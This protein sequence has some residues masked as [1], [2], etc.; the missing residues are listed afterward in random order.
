MKDRACLGLVACGLWL[1]G[2]VK[3]VKRIMTQDNEM[4]R[5]Q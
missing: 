5:K 3:E 1:L 2:K 4:G